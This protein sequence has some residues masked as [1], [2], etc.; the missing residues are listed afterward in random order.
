MVISM[1]KIFI[2][3]L[4]LVLLCFLI[5]ILFTKQK[6]E[7][8]VNNE[9]EPIQETQVDYDYGKYNTIKLLHTATRR[10]R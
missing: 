7:L 3:I 6:R 10:S 5:P 8:E 2:Y 1:K 9:E 4:G